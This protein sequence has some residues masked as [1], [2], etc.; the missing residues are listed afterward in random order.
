MDIKMMVT[1]DTGFEEVLLS[2]L[3]DLATF[4]V[5]GVYSGRVFIEVPRGEDIVGVMRS[6]IA[7][8][9]YVLIHVEENVTD[10]SAIYRVVKGLDFTKV[11]EPWETFAIRPERIG[12]HS[13][14]SIDIGR[15]A[16][17]AVIDGYIEA[18]GSRLRVNL[19]NPDVEIYVELNVDR[20]IVALSLTR[21]SYH[22]RGYKVF[23][24]PAGL[25]PT[26]AFA[27]LKIANWSYGKPILDPM[28]GGGT[29]AI[30]AALASK[31]LE[32]PCLSVGKIHLGVLGRIYPEA[33]EVLQNIC[34]YSVKEVDR[35]FIGV[36]IN[37]RFVE[38]AIINA[39][40]AGV[41]DATLFLV[42]DSRYVVPKIKAV[43]NEF[44][45]VFDTAVFNPP[46]GYRMKPGSL[47]ELYKDILKVLIDQGFKNIAFITSAT[48]VSEKVL[49]NF[50]GTDI[51]RLRVIHGTLPS[52]VYRL[53]L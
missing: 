10:L 42:G 13:F 29:I 23:V 16:G 30:E 3:K 24:H 51:Y 9:V 11:I 48:K 40:N 33:I 37:P 4:K 17:Q 6:R 38:G 28:C 12:E 18:R 22:A 50:S 26:I 14:T 41:D 39:K 31:G 32:I 19:D 53:R 1:C 47:K 45:V 44:G 52:I 46:Y 21:S 20:L 43:E 8:N 7:N 25:K 49:E 34:E 27:L 5:L 35:V 36:D 15:I 2:E